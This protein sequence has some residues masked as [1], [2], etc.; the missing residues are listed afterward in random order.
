MNNTLNIDL[1]ILILSCVGWWKSL[2]TIPWPGFSA[3]VI[4]S[5]NPL[6][7]KIPTAD[8]LSVKTSERLAFVKL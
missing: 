1:F 3:D 6:L 4:K 8:Q 5:K 7:K 2:S